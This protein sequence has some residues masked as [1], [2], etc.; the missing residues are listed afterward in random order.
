[1]KILVTG[2]KGF[3]GKNL[4]LELR[5]QGYQDIFEYDMDTKEEMLNSWAKECD[6]VFHL[7]GVNRP[8]NPDE[9][10]KGNFGFTS[11]LLDA[12]V[13]NGNK[14]P[15]LI[16][17]SIQAALDNPYGNS[18]REGEKLLFE[19]GA[20]HNVRTCVYRLPNVFG[21]WCRPNYNS[22]VAT[23]CHNIAN[24]LEIKV[25]DPNVDMQLVYV[26]DVVGQ[27]I[28]ALNNNEIKENEFCVIPTV[29]EVKLGMIV[30]LIYSFKESRNNLSV[31]ELSNPFINV[32]YS[33]YLSYLP[34]DQFSYPLKMNVDDRGS[35]TEIIRTSDRGQISV[36]ISKPGITKGNHWHHTKNEKFIV[37]SGSG[38]IQ[39]RKIGTDEV[40]D[41]YVSGKNIE[42]VDI[43]TGYTHNIINKGD[44]DL[45]TIM[46]ANEAFNNE[47][48]D[49]Y[50][51]KV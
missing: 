9:F 32:L 18:K 25:N 6:F 21:K 43:P 50:F 45:V 3:I 30:D 39:F 23:F 5:N 20:K 47:K 27:F 13:R 7:A 14:C 17:S 34:K 51:E 49:T 11:T 31:P 16:T 40:I 46:W 48:P 42:V 26:D 33:T 28:N 4:V 37:V 44:T 36:N 10:M 8:E 24:N 35:F 2:A 41:Y 15:I 29:Y 1:M 22:A 12:L 19:Y 38:L